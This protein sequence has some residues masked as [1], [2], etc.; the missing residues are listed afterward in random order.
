MTDELQSTLAGASTVERRRRPVAGVSRQGAGAGSRRRHQGAPAGHRMTVSTVVQPQI[1]RGALQHAHIV[2][3]R[4]NE[5]RLPFY[6]TPL[7]Q[8]ET[9]QRLAHEHGLRRSPSRRRAPAG[10]RGA[11]R[12]GKLAG[13]FANHHG[14]RGGRFHL[15]A[16]GDGARR[17]EPRALVRTLRFPRRPRSPRRSKAFLDALTLHRCR[18][19]RVLLWRPIIRIMQTG[20]NRFRLVALLGSHHSVRNGYRLP[21]QSV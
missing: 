7:V 12:S 20:A 10:H 8:G 13:R 16:H 15:S 17:A 18:C 5:R 14:S 19:R 2:P 21:V 6:T 3:P 1:R 4:R 9:L 11:S